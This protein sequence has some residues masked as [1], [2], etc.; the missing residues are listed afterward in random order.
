MDEAIDVDRLRLA[1]LRVARSIRTNASGAI[2]P[3][4][5]AVLMTVGAHE[6]ISVGDI[7][8]RERVR[9]PSISKIVATLEAAGYV[10]RNADPAD[11][12]C[13]LVSQ[14]PDGRA[15]AES[16]RAAGRTWLAERLDALTADDRRA[17]GDAIVALERLLPP[18]DDAGSA[19]DP[20]PEAR[21]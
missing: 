3:S 4:Q 6:P 19:T 12:R 20:D 21:S 2:T 14:T 10:E 5:L 8:E 16:V 13:A 17:I 9:P 1:M 18:T 15:Y 11:R 7:A